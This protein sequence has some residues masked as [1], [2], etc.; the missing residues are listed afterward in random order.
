MLRYRVF[1]LFA[2]LLVSL[3]TGC[4]GTRNPQ[5]GSSRAITVST[6]DLDLQSGPVRFDLY[7]SANRS[8]APAPLVVVAHG[9]WRDR[10]HMAGW[11][12]L[13]A[14]Q[15]FIVAVPNMPTL[16]DYPRNAIAI[17][18]LVHSLCDHPIDSCKIDRNRIGMIGLSAG[19]L[20]TLLAAADNPDVKVWVGLDPVDRGGLGVAAAP[21]VRARAFI[22]RAP[23]S[24][25]NSDGNAVV[26]RDA[27]PNVVSDTLVP[28]AI[29][30]DPEW[31]SDWTMELL[32][33]SPSEQRRDEFAAR[34]TSALRHE[35][36]DQPTPVLT[37]IE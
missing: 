1:W 2:L 26:L 32:I 4:A 15:G 13:L 21:R 25:W 33:G 7:R 23:A 5:S 9:L 29:H 20:A 22:V 16:S 18:E 10:T 12:E 35:L 24:I 31:P 8:T 19:G 37:K 17:N 6:E 30:I 34:A 28:N 11:G 14:Q 36:G 3:L 27:L